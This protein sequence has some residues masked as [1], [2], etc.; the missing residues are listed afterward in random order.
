MG[1]VV[2]LNAPQADETNQC[3]TPGNGLRARLVAALAAVQH[4]V[5]LDILERRLKKP[6]NE[7]TAALSALVTAGD[8][9]RIEKGLYEATPQGRER[10]NKRVVSG[11]RKPHSGPGKQRT[12][13]FRARLW[14][15]LRIAR[16]LPLSE[17]VMLARD[18]ADKNPETNARAYLNALEKAGYVHRFPQR[19]PYD[20][21]TSNGFARWGILKDTGPKPPVFN[22]D[23]KT[24]RDPNTGETLDLA[25]GD[26]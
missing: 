11:P 10:A 12:G 15:V 3:R 24:L 8:V 4:P 2:N 13:T 23:K 17:L 1:G 18:D 19:Q 20:G 25:G 21:S 9:R 6:R 22:P 5:R 16:K 26:A 14:K 7:I